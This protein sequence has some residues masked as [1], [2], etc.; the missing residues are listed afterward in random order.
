[1]R[2]Y[3]GTK[4]KKVPEFEIS[5]SM[6][7]DWWDDDDYDWYQPWGKNYRKYTDFNVSYSIDSVG[8]VNWEEEYPISVKRGRLIDNILSRKEDSKLNTLSNFW[9]K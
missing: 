8:F 2:D 3:F 6:Y 4:Y 7:W 1:M 5:E 9:P